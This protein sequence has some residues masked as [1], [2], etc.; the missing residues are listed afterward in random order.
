MKN[1]NLKPYDSTAF[2]GSSTGYAGQGIC[3]VCKTNGAVYMGKRG[4]VM[5]A[6]CESCKPKSK[7]EDIDKL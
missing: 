4:A 3:S 7:N 2:S 6:Y 5:L 1:N